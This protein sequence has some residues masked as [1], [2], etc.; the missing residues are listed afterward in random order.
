MAV[1]MLRQHAS[2]L[3]TS[4]RDVE[5]AK[6]DVGVG[7]G[8]ALLLP[9][10][11]AGGIANGYIGASRNMSVLGG[12]PRL[13]IVAV[14]GLICARLLAVLIDLHVGGRLSGSDL[15]RYGVRLAL[16]AVILLLF[17]GAPIRVALLAAG[18]AVVLL[19]GVSRLLGCI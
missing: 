19:P 15:K 6:L 16:Y 5:Q 17:G 18:I 1:D 13:L 2:D 12:S 3:M 8:T 10:V 9:V 11:G 14:V 7:I 4:A